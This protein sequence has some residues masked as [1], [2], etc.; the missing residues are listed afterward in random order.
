MLS[1]GRSSKPIHVRV[2]TMDAEL[3]FAILPSATGK[4]LFD[5]VVKTIGLREVWFF[6]LQY[7]DNKDL[8]TWLKMKKKVNQQDVKKEQPLQFKFRA[9]F[10]PEDV[11]EELIQEVTQ[12]LFFLQVKDSILSEEY[13]CPPETSVLL[14]SYAVQAKYGDNNP[15]VHKSG[16]LSKERLL[17]QRV[18]DQHRI[19]KEQWEERVTNWHKEHRGMLREDAMLEYLKIAQGL[20]MYGVNYFEITNRKGT[21]LWLGV[22]ALGLNVYEYEDKLTPK[23]G[24]P[25]SEVRNISFDKKMFVIKPSD[26]KAPSFVFFASFLRINRRI[27]SLCM[28]NHELYM[29]R[30]QPD[31]IEVQQMRVQAREEKA[32]K[33]AERA[34]L[35]RERQAR[36][37]AERRRKE[38]EKEV[39]KYES[40]MRRAMQALAKS[41]ARAKDLESTVESAQR[42]AEERDRLRAEA[43]ALMREAQQQIEDMKNS[44]TL[45]AEEREAAI[46]RSR[47]VEE[48]AQAMK[49]DADERDAEA[50]RLQEQLNAAKTQ[51]LQDAKALLD[52]TSSTKLKRLSLSVT[53]HN[54][55]VDGDDHTTELH[56]GAGENGDGSASGLGAPASSTQRISPESVATAQAGGGGRRFFTEARESSY[57]SKIR[58]QLALLGRD[59]DTA[60]DPTKL[61]SYDRLHVE[62][63]RHGRDK[64]KTLRKIRSGNTRQRI[65]DFENM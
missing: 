27:L 5:Q 13:Y 26:K 4:Q 32:V 50:K 20:E 63:V 18:I 41:E 62:N 29:R 21:T 39:A 6:G 14:A 24:F 35:A 43:E 55:E 45:S 42:Q 61:T 33:H 53:E 52:A 58:E 65:M 30:R 37:D 2:T 34:L 10:F 1:V 17:P 16:F 38:M 19:S 11:A 8:T 48:R 40:D 59:L 36:L 51:Q 31:S 3:E 57:N 15:A 44:L 12:R 7:K 64:F 54:D 46:A 47:E 9:K 25:W 22:D 23:I 60:K 49:R 28:G 56:S